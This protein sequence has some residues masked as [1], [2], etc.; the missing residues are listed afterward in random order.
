L[1]IGRSIFLYF[2]HGAATE[3]SDV[4]VDVDVDVA[5]LAANMRSNS[6]RFSGNPFY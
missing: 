6:S 4:D 5:V 2:A 1:I 3:N